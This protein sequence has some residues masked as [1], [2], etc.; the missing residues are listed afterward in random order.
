MESEGSATSQAIFLVGLTPA[1]V[2]DGALKASWPVGRR[3]LRY[4]DQEPETISHLLLGCVFA[5]DVW[6]RM[7]QPLGLDGLMP[8]ADEDLVSWWLR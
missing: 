1:I 8:N 5:R 4:L 6:F 7:L 3:H 2:D